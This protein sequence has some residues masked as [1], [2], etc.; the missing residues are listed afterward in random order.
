[1][2]RGHR[3]QLHMA[4][5]RQVWET[6]FDSALDLFTAPAQ[7]SGVAAV[8]PKLFAVLSDKVQHGAN[9]LAGLA[10][11]PA[12]KLLQEYRG[13]V[14]RSK[15]QQGVDGRDAD[16]L[17]EPVHREDDADLSRGKSLQCLP[18]LFARSLG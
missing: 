2:L 4:S 13:A 1:M 8:H 5:A 6:L 12:P 9:A 16:A 17:S 3:V 18:S 15:Q 7:K 11:Q 10:P 14:S